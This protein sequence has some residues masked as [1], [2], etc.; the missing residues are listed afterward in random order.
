MLF[1][2]CHYRI[3]DLISKTRAKPKNLLLFSYSSNQ[4]YSKSILEFR[5]VKSLF[6]SEFTININLF[7]EII[8]VGTFFPSFDYRKENKPSTI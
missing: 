3:I 2:L 4:N 8:E 7:I 6:P 1:F 5:A